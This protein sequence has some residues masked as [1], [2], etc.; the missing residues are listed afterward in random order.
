MSQDNIEEVGAFRDEREDH[1]DAD[2]PPVALFLTQ[3]SGEH[4]LLFSRQG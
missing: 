1:S 3:V 4:G 2:K